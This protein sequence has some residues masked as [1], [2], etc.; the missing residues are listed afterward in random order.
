MTLSRITATGRGR[1]SA[2]L[3][4]EGWECEYVS[5]KRMERTTSDG[6]SRV[7]GLDLADM[8]IGTSVD[9]MRAKLTGTSLTAR[10]KDLDRVAGKR[11]GRVTR[12]LWRSPTVRLYLGANLAWGDTSLTLGGSSGAQLPSSGVVH[13]GTEAIEYATNIA[14]VLGG[15]TR[16]LWQSVA[17]S[18]YIADG[19]GLAD[20]LIH[21]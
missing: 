7:N 9:L 16:G 21:P 3:V 10:I 11:H 20:A 15:L 14:G 5:A 8:V 2:R 6:R 4:L 13:V 17:Q 12:S 18:H 19:E 1:L